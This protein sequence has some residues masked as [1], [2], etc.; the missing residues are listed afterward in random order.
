LM[1]PV[2]EQVWGHSK[3]RG[4]S[5]GQGGSKGRW[6]NCVTSPK[7]NGKLALLFRSL[8][9]SSGAV[10]WFSEACSAAATDVLYIAHHATP[11]L[12]V[13]NRLISTALGSNGRLGDAVC[14]GSYTVVV[15]LH[16]FRF[17]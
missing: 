9:D 6:I 7:E 8:G 5:K 12:F 10:S 15:A 4:R 3:G 13:T 17:P 14:V 1:F 2:H 11:V 16:T